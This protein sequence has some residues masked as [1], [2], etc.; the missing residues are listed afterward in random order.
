MEPIAPTLPE[1]PVPPPALH[2]PRTRPRTAG[3]VVYGRVSR[4]A[5]PPTN[6]YAFESKSQ[7]QN[8]PL[9]QSPQSFSIDCHSKIGALNP[10]Q[11]RYA[12]NERRDHPEPPRGPSV[13]SENLSYL[14]GI[15]STNTPQPNQP[16]PVIDTDR[17]SSEALST[18]ASQTVSLFGGGTE[19]AD[20]ICEAVR[21]A[22]DICLQS[23]Q[24]WLDTHRANRLA[25][26]SDSLTLSNQPTSYADGSWY[27]PSSE[28]SNNQ[29]RSTNSL[30][31]NVS[32]ICGMLWTNSQRDRL[33][34]LNVE[35]NAVDNMGRL[36]CWAET[37]ALGDY[38]EW[39]MADNEALQ[40][41]M[42]A[43]K[44][45]CAWLGLLDGMQAMDAL[46]SEVRESFGFKMESW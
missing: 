21:A 38:D 12:E 27:T 45:L 17:R 22:H 5:R 3:G 18:D 28:H 10:G 9:C 44:D 8:V 13:P 37:V 24:M 35:R 46:E 7:S 19:R 29:N 6:P 31:K 16:I 26:A 43:G 15:T 20:Q 1:P 39:T 42:A 2:A 23:T 4:C 32:T 34:V 30:L 41:V 11:G 33:D 36:L 40:H 25:R 14:L